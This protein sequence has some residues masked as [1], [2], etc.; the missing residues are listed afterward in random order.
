MWANL[1]FSADLVNLLKKFSM[2]NFIFYALSVV[3]FSMLIQRC[4]QNTVKTSIIT[5]IKIKLY[6]FI[7]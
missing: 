4:I 5:I 3:I 6:G 7:L 1:Q 2:K